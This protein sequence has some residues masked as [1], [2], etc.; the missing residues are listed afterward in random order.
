MKILRSLSILA[1]LAVLITTISCS[2]DDD[3]IQE[4]T[5]QE[6]PVVTI[7]SPEDGVKIETLGGS[8][9]IIVAFEA[10]DETELG[11][12]V[13]EFD[14]TQILEV[15]TF[16]DFLNYLGEIVQEDVADGNHT[17]NVIVTDLAGNSTTGTVAFETGPYTPLS[18]E[19]AYFPFDGSN[20]SLVSEVTPTVV[21]TPGFTTDAQVGTNS[22]A[23]AADSY[24]SYPTTDFA[25]TNELTVSMFM[26]LEV[27][28]ETSRA[29]IFVMGPEDAANPDAQNVRTSGVRFFRE[30]SGTLQIFKWNF[31]T[32]EGEVW[33][34]GGN[35]AKLD[36]DDDEWH[37]FALV[38]TATAANFYIDGALV[39][40]RDEHVGLSMTGCD[41]LSIGS[42]APR[43]T[44]WSHLSDLSYID[45]VKIFNKA[46]SDAELTAASGVAITGVPDV[47]DP[48]DPGLT[49]LDGDDATELMSMSFDT[50]FSVAGIEATV[51]EVGSP[52]VV[53]GGVSGSAY[54]GDVDSYIT[55]P[56]E[57]LI[58]DSF[59][60]SFWIKMDPTATRAGIFTIS[61][62][63]TENPDSQNNR[64]AGVR[65]FREGNDASQTFRLNIGTGETSVTVSDGFYSAFAADR[66]DWLHVAFTV[67]GGQAQLYLNG[68]LS[69]V[70]SEDVVV[71]WTGCDLLSFGS[72]APRF[73]GWSH[74]G[75][76]GM[77]D[78][79]KI[80]SGVLTPAQVASLKAEGE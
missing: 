79:L 24:V 41:L 71:D 64:T 61:P 56:T 16:T 35:F 38:I 43:F 76:T 45:D 14:G 49:P 7:T 73:V 23:G 31:G 20:I 62:E 60:A 12:V 9:D 33:L 21:G 52:S 27:T 80:F 54:S 42:G 69:A 47:E 1:S 77:L 4:E 55:L 28:E 36:P 22:Y 65:L 34:D 29:G 72:G 78:E 11:S 57:G 48:G 58:N 2:K 19:V 25:I 10:S 53:D 39:A 6:N 5:D 75:E 3:P 74:L 13:V 68:I 63:D 66:E 50:D 32:G 70:S 17:V 15:T 8:T 18:G 51:T 26:K 46:L 30:N 37:H 40:S 59:S 44:G 67:G